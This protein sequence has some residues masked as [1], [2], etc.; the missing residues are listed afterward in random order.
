MGGCGINTIRPRA[1]L[2]RHV[3]NW[4][5]QWK[6]GVTP[7]TTYPRDIHDR[8]TQQGWTAVV[9]FPVSSSRMG[10]AGCGVLAPMLAVVLP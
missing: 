6:Q 9:E 1:D 7:G 4:C 10:L 3:D 2:Q 5:M 8:F